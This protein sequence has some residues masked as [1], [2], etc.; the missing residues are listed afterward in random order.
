MNCIEFRDLY[1]GDVLLL[2][3]KKKNK[4]NFNY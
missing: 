4:I 3:N 2:N 1:K